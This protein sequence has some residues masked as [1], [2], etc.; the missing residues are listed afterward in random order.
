MAALPVKQVPFD[1]TLS[2][3]MKSM[4]PWSRAKKAEEE[5]AA[6]DSREVPKVRT[7]IDLIRIANLD[8]DEVHVKT[9]LNDLNEAWKSGDPKKKED[10]RAKLLARLKE[11]GVDKLTHRQKLAN[12]FSSCKRDGRL[13]P[14]KDETGAGDESAEADGA[15]ASQFP[16][17][18]TK[19]EM[20]QAAAM[21]IAPLPG[22]VFDAACKGTISL[23]SAWLSASDAHNINARDSHFGATMLMAAAL[24]GHE[25]LVGLLLQRGANIDL[26]NN[27]GGTALINAAGEG[28]AVVVERLLKEGADAKLRHGRGLS[29]LQFAEQKGH[30]EV[31]ALLRKHLGF[32]APATASIDPAAHP[33]SN[34]SCCHQTHPA[35]HPS[36]NCTGAR[37]LDGS[38][39]HLPGGAH[40]EEAAAAAAAKNV[41][42]GAEVKAEAA[43][44]AKATPLR[45]GQRVK[46]IA[47]LARPDLNGRLATVV[48]F[49]AD[50]G[51]YNVDVAGEILAL[52]PDNLM[53]VDAAPVPVS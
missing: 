52:R 8:E 46:I 9:S 37:G 38:A 33:S 17:P 5:L 7:V 40:P 1:V 35:A 36:S 32:E 4:D 41:F 34:S 18:I 2:D 23:V 6:K 24:G 12:A 50:R 51:R 13:R 53:L 25:G 22:N 30:S 20:A 15:A 31:A 21:T 39:A 26:Q 28:H 48:A 19:A 3:A 11:A 29:A 42:A 45:D 27:L 16:R 44:A 10:G 14:V 49:N 43:A 47:L